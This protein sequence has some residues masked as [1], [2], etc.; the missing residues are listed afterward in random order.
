MSHSKGKTR[1]LGDVIC[2]K[3]KTVPGPRSFEALYPLQGSLREFP[4]EIDLEEER[5]GALD[6]ENEQ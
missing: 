5:R 1:R 6:R 4:L 3:E 2:S